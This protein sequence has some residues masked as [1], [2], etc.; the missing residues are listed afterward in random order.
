MFAVKRRRSVRWCLAVL[1]AAACAAFAQHGS[2]QKSSGTL[3]VTATVVGSVAVVPAPNGELKVVVA[4]APDGTFLTQQALAWFQ[5]LRR[6]KIPDR[7]KNLQ[8]QKKKGTKLPGLVPSSISTDE[9][10][11]LP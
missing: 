5:N 3:E 4:N 6:E 10:C 1:L 2:Q 11:L 7:G 9:T 8:Q